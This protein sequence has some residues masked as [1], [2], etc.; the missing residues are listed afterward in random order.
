MISTKRLPCY[1]QNRQAL[2]VVQE[3]GEV[4]VEIWYESVVETVWDPSNSS[5][6]QL[7][8]EQGLKLSD[9]ASSHHNDDVLLI[10][11]TKFKTLYCIKYTVAISFGMV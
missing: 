10:C 3:S 6:P 9:H 1:T 8:L 4:A 2:F 5:S 7:H 11:L